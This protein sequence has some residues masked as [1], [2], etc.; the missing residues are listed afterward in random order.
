[1]TNKE[2]ITDDLVEEFYDDGQLKL[3][4]NLKNGVRYGLQEVF[5]KDGSIYNR[6]NYK[7]GYAHGLFE[8]FYDNGQLKTRRHFREGEKHGLWEWFDEKKGLTKTEEHKSS[9]GTN[10]QNKKEVLK[11]LEGDFRRFRRISPELRADIEVKDFALSCAM[12]Q[13]KDDYRWQYYLLFSLGR[14]FQSIHVKENK[15]NDDEYLT[16]KIAAVTKHNIVYLNS[17]SERLKNDVEFF[18]NLFDV[19]PK[20]FGW[21]YLKYASEKVRC[22]EELALKAIACSVGEINFVDES[23]LDDYRFL[24]RALQANPRVIEYYTKDLLEDHKFIK[25]VSASQLDLVKKHLGLKDA[26]LTANYENV[27]PHLMKAVIEMGA[28]NIEAVLDA[29]QA[30]NISFNFKWN[31]HLGGPVIQKKLE[32]SKPDSIFEYIKK[33]HLKHDPF[34]RNKKDFVPSEKLFIELVSKNKTIPKKYFEDSYVADNDSFQEEFDGFGDGAD[35]I[36]KLAL[37]I[38]VVDAS[39]PAKGFFG[40][41]R[42]KELFTAHADAFIAS[43]DLSGSP[44][45]FNDDL[46][47]SGTTK[48]ISHILRGNILRVFDP[49][50]EADLSGINPFLLREKDGLYSWHRSD[51]LE[52][53]EDSMPLLLWDVL[54]NIYDKVYY[55]QHYENLPKLLSGAVG[56][57]WT[58][59]YHSIVCERDTVLDK[60]TWGYYTK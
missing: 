52:K 7:D 21:D 13:E 32:P 6:G 17:L 40:I 45:Y 29:F 23:L 44:T 34:N 12:K 26:Q 60:I 28:Q 50:R 57:M 19:R 53:I 39:D 5:R 38:D 41:F 42:D 4:R 18:K 25:H 51:E 16:L 2:E 8:D 24:T 43:G 15:A 48:T 36:G 30:L 46:S 20:N 11:A 35:N 31:V 33:L 10:W 3:R 47:L 49:D 22:N 14:D 27:G 58:E 9:W 55:C 56:M 37:F 54:E 1:M 59:C